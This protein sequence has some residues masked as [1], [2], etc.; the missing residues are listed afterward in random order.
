MALSTFT[1]T[2][3]FCFLRRTHEIRVSPATR[4]YFMWQGYQLYRNFY[5][6]FAHHISLQSYNVP[7]ST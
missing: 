5:Q 3:H 4:R 6:G 7:Q 2:L 1:Y